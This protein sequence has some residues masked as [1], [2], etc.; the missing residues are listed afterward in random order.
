MNENRSKL[1]PA[2]LVGA[3]ILGGVLLFA[4]AQSNNDE[5]KD[6]KTNTSQQAADKPTNDEATMPKDIVDTAV[7]TAPLSTLVTAVKTAGLVDTLKGEGP[8]TVLAPTNAAFDKL[9]AGTVDTLL[10]P[11]SNEQ[12]KSILTYHVIAGKV[13]SNQL[14]NGQVVAT[15][16]GQNLTVEIMDGKVYFVDAKGGKAQ[17]DS[18]DVAATNGVVH[19]IDTVLMPQ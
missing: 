3:L 8:F 16:Q 12:L 18:P 11:E 9:P 2:L 14:T 10:K 15:V 13:M 19:V 17:V 4:N 6:T 5:T 1:L 7:A